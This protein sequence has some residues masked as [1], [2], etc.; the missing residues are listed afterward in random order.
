MS[1]GMTR[2]IV[3][4]GKPMRVSTKR[5]G[6]KLNKYG[7]RK[8]FVNGWDS[9]RIDPYKGRSNFDGIVL[10]HTAGL[11]SLRYICYGNPYAPV[12]AAHFYVD[13]EGMVFVCSGVGA[14]HA[15]KG[16]PWTFPKRGKDVVIP[17]DS[18]N[19][20][21]YGIEIE[22]LGKSRKI[23]GS[24]EG[25]TVEQIVSTSLLCAA[26][27]NAMKVGPG[28]LPVSRV[29]RHRDWTS[30]KI[31]VKQDLDWWHQAIGISRRLKGKPA[32]SEALVRE[33]VKEHPRGRL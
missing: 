23:D 1:I 12:R 7:M 2:F 18:G 3:N 6:F 32:A 33:F 29:I 10:H 4:G 9:P 20:R 17:K 24:K 16:G 13:R 22:S 30:R 21:L 31:D 5:L 19:S 11:D 14:Y 8:Q 26:L 28:S 15:G 25:M 27:L